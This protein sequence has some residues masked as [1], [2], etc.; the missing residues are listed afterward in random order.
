MD[1]D[2]VASYRAQADF[3]GSLTEWQDKTESRQRVFRST[4]PELSAQLDLRWKADLADLL[5]ERSRSNPLFMI[6][7]AFGNILRLNPTGTAYNVSWHC[8]KLRRA[9]LSNIEPLD[10]NPV[11]SSDYIE[12]IRSVPEAKVER[13]YMLLDPPY[14]RPE[15]TKMTPCYPGHTPNCES[16]R[17][18]AT[19]SL[20]S[21]LSRGFPKVSLC[22]YWDSALDD[23]IK[24]TCMFW[25]YQVELQLL[26]TMDSFNTAKG[27]LVHGQ[28]V[29]SRP[30]PI[31]AIW[32]IRKEM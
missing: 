30:K 31:E 3:Y 4:Y 27:R 9:I 29:D 21:A 13:T 20:D 2:F 7:A 32:T 23:Q 12:A 15:G 28:R 25:G 8:E 16:T 5:L 11:V 6:R 24:L 18:L 14:L 17:Q 1:S 22:N 10:W 26:G 19:H